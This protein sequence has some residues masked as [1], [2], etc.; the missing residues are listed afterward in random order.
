M[1]QT[2]QKCI[3]TEKAGKKETWQ[4]TWANAEQP[5]VPVDPVKNE[6]CGL[7]IHMQQDVSPQKWRLDPALNHFYVMEEYLSKVNSCVKK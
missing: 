7:T 6:A 1:R 5:G 2:Q 4:I 3:I